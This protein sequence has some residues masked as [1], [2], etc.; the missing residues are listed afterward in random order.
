MKPM[1]SIAIPTYNRAA[2]LDKSLT[3]LLPQVYLFCENIE[4]IISDNASDDD[5]QKIIQKHLQSYPDIRFV[6][7][8]QKYNTG[9]YGNF[10]KCRELSTGEYFWL[11]SDNEHLEE[12]VIKVLIKNLAHKNLGCCF[13]LNRPKQ[14]DKKFIQYVKD[15]ESVNNAWIFYK[16]TLISSVVFIN[17]KK[18]DTVIF[19]KYDQNSFLGFFFLGS[20]L[21]QNS[22]ILVIEGKIYQSMP[23]NVYFN[24]FESWT[25]HINQAVDF[26]VDLSIFDSHQKR[27]FINSFLK[28][29][30]KFHVKNYRIDNVLQGRKY[31]SIQ[32]IKLLLDRYYSSN[33]SYN[34]W[35]VPVYGQNLYFLKIR[36]MISKVVRKINSTFL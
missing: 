7:Y 25:F 27:I 2:I 31:G 12:D 6:I 24:I 19:E 23:C 34:D 10:K 1:L 13:F 30:V 32:D 26:F 11:L 16:F 5:T 8:K 15:V 4:L 9:Y 18:F 33:Q 36:K 28:N 14:K 3:K 29:V 20:A 17:N 22:S 35:I 21:K